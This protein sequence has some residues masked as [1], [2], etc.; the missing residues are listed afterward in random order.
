[1]GNLEVKLLK[2]LESSQEDKKIITSYIEN[3]DIDNLFENYNELDISDDTKDQ[4]QSLIIIL[5][6]YKDM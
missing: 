5:E 4:I 3:S 6:N 1:M 2:L